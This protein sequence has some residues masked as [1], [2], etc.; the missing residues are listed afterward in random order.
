MLT[1][2]SDLAR[3]Q[4]DL[5]ASSVGYLDAYLGGDPFLEFVQ[6]NVWMLKGDH[7]KA[8]TAFLSAIKRDPELADAYDGLIAVA[9]ARSD[10][11]GVCQVLDKLEALEYEVDLDGWSEES[12]YAEFLASDVYKAWL[13]ARK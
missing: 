2:G 4:H 9:I 8:K 7:A 13:A 6:G 1:I 5:V 10:F 11:V 3:G 12:A